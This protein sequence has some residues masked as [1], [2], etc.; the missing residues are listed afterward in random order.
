MSP[1]QTMVGFWCRVGSSVPVVP[2]IECGV[3]KTEEEEDGSVTETKTSRKKEEVEEEDDLINN[4]LDNDD[5]ENNSEPMNQTDGNSTEASEGSTTKL[6]SSLMTTMKKKVQQK[7]EKLK[8]SIKKI[9]AYATTTT[10]YAFDLGETD[11]NANEP[12]GLYDGGDDNEITYQSDLM[13]PGRNIFVVTTA[14][15]PWF[16]GT[17]VNPLLRA[18]YLFRMTQD[19]RR[20]A[21]SSSLDKVNETRFND[22]SAAPVSNGT[23]ELELEEEELDLGPARMVTLVIPW[24]E[25]GEDRLHLYGPNINFTTPEEQELYIRKWLREEAE[26]P[27]EADAE[28]G[29]NIFFYPARYH[30]SLKLIFAMGDIPSLIPDEDADV[31][32]L[33]EPEHLN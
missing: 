30:T 1:H 20:N 29:L 26:M 21:T 12:V 9:K 27:A 22:A 11:N 16:T 2:K 7:Q 18:A 5:D 31:C 14:S 3:S 17:A 28:T 23:T 4:L 15:I 24:L 10:N 32:I 19:I 8:H 13:R 25:L 6:S 33:E